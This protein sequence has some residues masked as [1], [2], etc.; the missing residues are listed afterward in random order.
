M[1]RGRKNKYVCNIIIIQKETKDSFQMAKAILTHTAVKT[2]NCILQTCKL[3]ELV[4]KPF[5]NPD[6]EEQD[7]HFFINSE[8]KQIFTC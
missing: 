5:H 4:L 3:F 2:N 1:I 8:N 6:R 7:A